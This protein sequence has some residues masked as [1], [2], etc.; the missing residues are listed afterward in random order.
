[1]RKQWIVCFLCLLTFTTIRADSAVV[2]EQSGVLAS[3]GE[4]VLSTPNLRP[5]WYL[6]Q[7]KQIDIDV[8]V[9]AEGESTPRVAVQTFVER[10]GDEY[11]AI[12]V[13]NEESL[14][15]LLTAPDQQGTF[16]GRFELALSHLADGD[17]SLYSAL[18]KAGQFGLDLD[19]S[20]RRETIGHLVS[21]LS[22]ADKASDLYASILFRLAWQHAWLLD[23]DTAVEYL[24]E[25]HVAPAV[26][27]DAGWQAAGNLL[28]GITFM[29]RGEKFHSDAEDALRRGFGYYDKQENRFLSGMALNSLGLLER[30]KENFDSAISLYSAAIAE[31]QPLGIDY[32]IAQS[33]GNIAHIREQERDFLTAIAVYDRALA[34]LPTSHNRLDK[35]YFMLNKASALRRYGLPNDALLMLDEVEQTL[36]PAA[37]SNERIWLLTQVAA[38]YR[39]VGNFRRAAEIQEQ[40]VLLRQSI[41]EGAADFRALIN[42]GSN[43]RSRGDRGD[44]QRAIETHERARSLAG[45]PS[46]KATALMELAYDAIES[47]S[48]SQ[49]LA[50]AEQSQQSV[51]GD[52]AD[53]TKHQ[54]SLLLSELPRD[55]IADKRNEILGSALVLAQDE[56]L[57]LRARAKRTLARLEDELAKK[58][59]YLDSA[60]ADIDAARQAISNPWLGAHLAAVEYPLIEDYLAAVWN[61]DAD[62]QVQHDAIVLAQRAR[63]TALTQLLAE[64]GA[65][66]TVERE[67]GWR[68]TGE[69][70]GPD[71]RLT[72]AAIRR[73]AELARSRA[74]DRRYQTLLKPDTT[75]VDR[76][77]KSLPADTGVLFYFVGEQSGVAW[78]LTR[79]EITSWALPSRADLRRA[80]S[81]LREGMSGRGAEAQGRLVG[82]LRET[83]AMV[84]PPETS[85]RTTKLLIVPDDALATIPFSALVINHENQA[86]FLVEHASVTVL[87][88]LSAVPDRKR[89]SAINV[90]SL[91]F[92]GSSDAALSAARREATVISDTLNGATVDS[93][94]GMSAVDALTNLRDARHEVVHI[95]AHSNPVPTAPTQARIEFG[96]LPQENF[97]VPELYASSRAQIEL[98]FLSA[99]ETSVGDYIRGDAIHGLVRAMLYAG[100]HNVVATNW[101]VSDRA[102]A[103]IIG[104]FYNAMA[105]TDGDVASA[106]REIQLDL[107]KE[108]GELRHPAYWAAYAHFASGRPL[109]RILE[110]GE[111]E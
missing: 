6:I 7:V 31:Y 95:A 21:A 33:L 92:L 73:D 72:E 18:T 67:R 79:T 100:A 109:Q 15:L 56:N 2:F 84:L 98:V 90:D 24:K 96:P 43:Y 63:S 111:R 23:L 102:S 62:E 5:G 60:L 9:S 91:L 58:T 13:V 30:Y 46:Q 16:K 3:G 52:L 47:E 81:S 80:A 76:V 38:I 87:P 54:V 68:F 66:E 32:R 108:K 57:V 37:D 94:F 35:I 75:T 28:S 105:N 110:V 51:E 29:E 36:A 55:M 59:D 77:Q 107:L 14:Q 34:L 1:M 17:V 69:L 86:G 49:A 78:Y 74:Q 48:Y 39:D 85:I 20:A 53:A 93:Y 106:I 19:N 88:T 82:W 44:L 42:L 11:L 104:R 65:F 41:N 12:Q 50:L 64:S 26:R 89:S 101:R 70:L 103:E 99:C 61:P 8:A 45:N 4:V 71:F 27:V 22:I 25:F 83:S 40:V 97:H 10:F